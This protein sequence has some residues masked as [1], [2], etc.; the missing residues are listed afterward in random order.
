MLRHFA[1]LD[2][3]ALDQYL[4]QLEGSLLE[5]LGK[6]TSGRRSGKA[7][8]SQGMMSA[9]VAFGKDVETTEHRRLPAASRFQRV[10][11]MLSERDEIQ[12]LEGFD[13]GIWQQ[14]RRGEFLE[15][16]ASVHLPESAKWS[17]NLPGIQSMISVM[18]QA[19]VD[20]FEGNEKADAYRAMLEML[21]EPGGAPIPITFESVFTGGY[22]FAGKLKPSYLRIEP[23]ELEGEYTVVGK[24]TRLVTEGRE[25][26]FSSIAP[27]LTGVFNL[28]NREQKRKAASSSPP[29]MMAEKITGP[30]A[31]LS[32]LAIFT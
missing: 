32:V 12:S 28:L 15:I 1:Y 16:P 23:L 13:E 25:E 11:E 8:I 24:I 4:G 5:D 21:V 22:T 17:Q 10:Y 31:I 7:G 30:A 9:E 27:Q 14:L 19:G 3:S 18:E 26:Q 20:P 6:R 2:E 29:P